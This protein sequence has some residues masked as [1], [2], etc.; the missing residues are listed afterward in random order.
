[1]HVESARSD[2]VGK[3]LNS[4]CD[5]EVI[6]RLRCFFP[7]LITF[8]C[9]RC[10]WVN[11]SCTTCRDAFV[12]NFVKIAQEELFR[13]YYDLYAKFED[14]TFNDFNVVEALANTNFLI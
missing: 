6:L 14:S 7:L 3:N 2:G 10:S 4:L 1:M 8:L 9:S 11:K 5:V 13:L 12:C